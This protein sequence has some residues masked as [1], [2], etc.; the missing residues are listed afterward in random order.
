MPSGKTVVIFCA[1][2]LTLCFIAIVLQGKTAQYQILESSASAV[3]KAQD[4]VTSSLKSDP[5]VRQLR[6]ME[7][8][9][10]HFNAQQKLKAIA[11]TPNK[12]ALRAAKTVKHDAL[13]DRG[14]TS[15][16]SSLEK[17]EMKAV[18][19]A[20]KTGH[21]DLKFND[22]SAK[23][24]EA[25]T[26]VNSIS[27]FIK[28]FQQ[29]LKTPNDALNRAHELSDLTHQDPEIAAA[30][31][32]LASVHKNDKVDEETKSEADHLG[33]NLKVGPVDF[34]QYRDRDQPF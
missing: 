6:A 25:A 30:K 18:K 29:K 3:R 11:R 20:K 10:R 19:K 21:M 34:S 9:Q 12:K 2:T 1:L 5:K 31:G 32:L 14:V 28:H 7:K 16:L 15:A 8:F 33:A 24:K 26:T 23:D 22:L 17:E 27:D 13:H 4:Y